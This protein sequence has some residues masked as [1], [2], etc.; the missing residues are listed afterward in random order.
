M[1]FIRR[2]PARESR[3]RF[4]SPEE[5][6]RGAVPVQEAN[7]LRPA[8]RVTSPTSARTR[9]ATHRADSGQVHQSGATG[10]HERLELGGGGLDLGVDRGQLG[11]LLGGDAASGLPGDVTWADVGE[12][13]LGLAGGDVALGLAGEQRG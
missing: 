11:Q 3:C 6:S 7:L 10:Q 12:H 1:W 2:F 4:C 5:A 8:N 9:A 13:L